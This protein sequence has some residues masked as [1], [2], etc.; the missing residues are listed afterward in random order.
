MS[1]GEPL[2]THT[3]TQT[4]T[5]TRR[6]SP[7]RDYTQRANRVVPKRSRSK[8]QQCAQRERCAVAATRA[9]AGF[10]GLAG[11]LAGRCVFVTFFGNAKPTTVGDWR[12]RVASNNFPAQ[13]GSGV[14]NI[15]QL[16]GSSALHD[17][18]VC[19]TRGMAILHID[20][21]NSCKILLLSNEHSASSIGFRLIYFEDSANENPQTQFLTL[22]KNI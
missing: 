10:S 9:P 11:W 14:L 19:W 7:R 4:L 1:S 2:R 17:I 22:C 18:E 21:S 6:Q 8:S 16:D 3:H 20:Q 13:N 5:V 15:F 12:R